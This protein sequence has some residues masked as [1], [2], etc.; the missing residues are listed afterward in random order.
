MEKSEYAPG[1]SRAEQISAFPFAALRL[2]SPKNRPISKVKEDEK[3]VQA[4]SV[5]EIPADSLY[6]V[7][8]DCLYRL[9]R[10]YNDRDQ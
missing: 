4:G 10:Y 1:R 6:Y 5:S 7:Y 3:Y 8:D 9:G 2:I